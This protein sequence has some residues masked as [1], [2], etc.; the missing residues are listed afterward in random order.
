MCFETQDSF[1]E[2]YVCFIC[3]EALGL[4]AGF[5]QAF[6]RSEIRLALDGIAREVFY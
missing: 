3:V 4:A 1:M 2:S 6:C 5:R